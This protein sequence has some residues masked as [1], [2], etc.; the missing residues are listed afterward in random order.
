MRQ[1]LTLDWFW[2]SVV[3]NFIVKLSLSKKPLTEVFY[4]SILTIVNQLIKEVW[5]IPYKKVSNAEELTY[6]FLQNVTALQDLS[7]EIIS[8]W[9]KLF[10]SN[11]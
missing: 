5:F 1:T 10:I 6:I 11:F 3:M 7:D 9:D 4:N 2:T 8:D